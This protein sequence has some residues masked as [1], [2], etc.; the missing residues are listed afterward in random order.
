MLANPTQNQGQ[1]CLEQTPL[2]DSETRG[3]PGAKEGQ[4][5]LAPRSSNQF[6]VG[7]PFSA[8]TAEN[9]VVNSQ[10]QPLTPQISARLDRGFDMIEGEWI[11]YKR[12]YFT[13]VAA[14]QFAGQPL[15]ITETD[16]FHHLDAEGTL[17]EIYAFKLSLTSVCLEDDSTAV[18]LVQHT[19]KRDRGPQSSPPLYHAVPGELPAHSTM[20]SVANIRNGDKIDRCN[21]LF[22]LS[23]ED[24]Q[25]AVRQN[26]ACVLATYPEDCEISLVARYERIQFS[27]A[28]CGNR[29]SASTNN[30]HYVLVVQL[31]GVTDVGNIVLASTQSPPL[32]VRGRSPSN[33]PLLDKKEAKEAKAEE[34]HVESGQANPCQDR[35]GISRSLSQDNSDTENDTGMAASKRR[36][37]KQSRPTRRPLGINREILNASPLKESGPTVSNS[38]PPCAPPPPVL[39][40]PL[41]HRTPVTSH[42]YQHSHRP[43]ASY[44]PPMDHNAGLLI[45]QDSNFPFYEESLSG[46]SYSYVSEGEPMNV[47]HSVFQSSQERFHQAM[48]EHEDSICEIEDYMNAELANALDCYSSLPTPMVFPDAVHTSTPL[49]LQVV[50]RPPAMRPNILRNLH[51]AVIR[52]KHGF[53]QRE[54]G[55]KVVSREKNYTFADLSGEIADNS[56]LMFRA[57]LASYKSRI[58]DQASHTLSSRSSALTMLSS[59]HNMF[60]AQD[61]HGHGHPAERNKP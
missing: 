13:L 15:D 26:P 57:K 46:N 11:G 17:S 12:N 47:N 60:F 30:K 44:T 40:E 22:Y 55:K 41:T 56:F 28:G 25:V 16:Q 45:A 2:T 34:S 33:Y 39:H 59:D 43:R 54:R 53:K 23:K 37:L 7:P 32:I 31:L 9:T 8:T 51:P 36:R 52:C 49:Q 42:P 1:L 5:R 24:H 3:T 14:F 18:T 48:L 4:R 50:N 21:R 38:P 29:K 61:F 27:S 35:R 10:K 20:K 58:R 19:A 6:R